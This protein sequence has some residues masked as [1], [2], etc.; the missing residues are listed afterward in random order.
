[1]FGDRLYVDLQRTA[2]R[3]SDAEACVIDFAIAATCR[4]FAPTS[5]I[6]PPSPI[7]NRT[8]RLIC[9]RPKARYVHE[10]DRRHLTAEHRYKTRPRCVNCS[11]TCRKPSRSTVEIGAALRFPAEDAPAE[12]C[13]AL[14]RRRWPCRRRSERIAQ[15]GPKAGLDAASPPGI[16]KGFTEEQYRR[17]AG[18]RTQRHREDEEYPG[19]FLIVADFIQWARTRAFRSG[20]A[21]VRAP[22]ARRIFA[23][24]HRSRSDP[25]RSAVRA[26]P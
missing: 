22:V 25:L 24:H 18:V 3:M 9:H 17:P 16:A 19:Y 11:P 20:R 14:G 1:L 21:V 8:T 4:W 15:P 5:R 23:D 13:R 6:S 26:L 7:M 12:S 2:P 10:T